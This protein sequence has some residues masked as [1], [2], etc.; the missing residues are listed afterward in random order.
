MGKTRKHGL[1]MGAAVAMAGLYKKLI[2]LLYLQREEAGLGVEGEVAAA[3]RAA[4]TAV[5][6]GDHKGIGNVE[7]E[8]LMHFS[9]AWVYTTMATI[10]VSILEKEK[11]YSEACELLRILLGEPPVAPEYIVLGQTLWSEVGDHLTLVMMKMENKV[12]GPARIRTASEIFPAGGK[13]CPTRRG[14]WWVRLTLNLSRHLK[15]EE[16]ALEVRSLRHRT[17]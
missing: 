10:Q 15:R 2:F 16:E 14:E 4:V 7:R 6:R 8:F 5:R 17:N 13:C 12:V 3:L 11:R 1:P 9:A